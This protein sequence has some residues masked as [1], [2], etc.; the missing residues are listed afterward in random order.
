MGALIQSPGCLSCVLC[1][2]HPRCAVCSLCHCP[3][4]ISV[5]ELCWCL[6][7]QSVRLPKC[8]LYVF[9]LAASG[10]GQMWTALTVLDTLHCTMLLWMVIS[11]S[12]TLPL[13]VRGAMCFTSCSLFMHSPLWC[14]CLWK[15][16][17]GATLHHLQDKQ[18]T[19]VQQSLEVFCA[20]LSVYLFNSLLE[21]GSFQPPFYLQAI[22]LRYNKTLKMAFPVTLLCSL[23]GVQCVA[24]PAPPEICCC[25]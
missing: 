18:R 6:F 25:V 20:A 13:I 17:D 4:T 11:E 9:C 15:C 1:D 12:F 21:H 3:I 23:S 19:S 5:W 22:W 2:A 14:C 24:V 8:S 7:L 16:G 10:E